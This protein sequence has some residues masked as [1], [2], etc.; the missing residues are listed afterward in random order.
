MINEQFTFCPK[1][2][3]SVKFTT[4]YFSVFNYLLQQVGGYVI[5]VSITLL[6]FRVLSVS[7]IMLIISKY[8]VSVYT[9]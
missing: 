4:F 1:I 2:L 7:L 8:A 5:V 9:C 6:Y 3:F